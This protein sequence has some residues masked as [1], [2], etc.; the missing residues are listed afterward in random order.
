MDWIDFP[1]APNIGDVICELADVSEGTT[2]AILTDGFG[3]LVV[4][5]KDHVWGFVNLCPHQFLPLTH[6]RTD[7]MS[8]D[9]TALLCSNH[10][11]RFDI[12][13]GQGETCALSKVPLQVV[14]GEI[15]I[16]RVKRA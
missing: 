10:S 4:R 5:R 7:I 6:R 3:F 9:A 8:A 15:V 16:G 2:K 12:E 11:M 14:D 13:T 1:N